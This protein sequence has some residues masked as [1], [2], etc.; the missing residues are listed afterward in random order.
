MAFG[1]LVDDDDVTALLE[2]R[3]GETRAERRLELRR[4][5]RPRYVA[6]IGYHRQARLL[7]VSRERPSRSR[8]ANKRNELA[9]LHGRPPTTA[10]PTTSSIMRCVVRHSKT[11]AA[12]GRSG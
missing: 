3:T 5:A 11:W 7:R 8:A 4:V 1:K 6:E 9:S 12:D 2:A 10:Q